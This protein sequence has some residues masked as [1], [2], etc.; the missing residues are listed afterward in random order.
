M[1][2][3][4]IPENFWKPNPLVAAAL[5]M[6]NRSLVD[7]DPPPRRGQCAPLAHATKDRPPSA[8]SARQRRAH[9]ATH[10]PP[11]GIIKPRR[12]GAGSHAA[13]QHRQL[14]GRSSSAVSGAEDAHLAGRFSAS[15]V[16][17]ERR[18]RRT[19]AAKLRYGGGVAADERA[20]LTASLAAYARSQAA[21]EDDTAV[22][23]RLGAMVV[24]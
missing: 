6:V 24:R 18:G 19:L 22:S 8:A 3:Y 10:T 5:A 1:C 13:L 15:V 16:V 21:A 2:D 11:R 17:S 9:E 14:P 12:T 7:N 20:Q 23:E 4:D